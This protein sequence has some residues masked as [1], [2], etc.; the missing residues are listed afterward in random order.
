MPRLNFDVSSL[1]D[2]RGLLVPL[3]GIARAGWGNCI[4]KAWRNIGMSS[5]L[6]L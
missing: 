4:G 1:V 3:Q 2:V 5:L 6:Y